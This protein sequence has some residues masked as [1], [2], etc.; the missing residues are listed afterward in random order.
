MVSP[1]PSG[2]LVLPME[3]HV[4]ATDV[5]SRGPVLTRGPFQALGQAL[6]QQL[7]DLVLRETSQE[8][9]EGLQRN[10]MEQSTLGWRDARFSTN[11]SRSL[12]PW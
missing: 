6:T 12:P 4:E 11:V 10:E 7:L 1:A 8:V 9:G 3:A 5:E 2:V